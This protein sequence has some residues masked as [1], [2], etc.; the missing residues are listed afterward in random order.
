MRNKT[1]TKIPVVLKHIIFLIFWYKFLIAECSSCAASIC[2]SQWM[3]LSL[4]RM[5]A[6]R[7]YP[8]K[9]KLLWTVN[10]VLM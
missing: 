5:L 9:L 3:N 8:L 6:G 7:L 1:V 4:E 2:V 10:K